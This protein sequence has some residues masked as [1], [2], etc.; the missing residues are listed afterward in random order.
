ME[1]QLPTSSSLPA[2][3]LALL[4]LTGDLFALPSFASFSILKRQLKLAR[5]GSGHLVS[6]FRHRRHRP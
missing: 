3:A 4:L 1:P 2:T 5:A 6:S